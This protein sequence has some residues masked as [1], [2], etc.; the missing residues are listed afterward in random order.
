M[1]TELTLWRI[2]HAHNELTHE[3]PCPNIEGSRR[4]LMSYLDSLM[5]LKQFPEADVTKGKMVLDENR[6]F[7]R[8]KQKEP[9]ATMEKQKWKPPQDN[10]AKM[11]VDG[12]FSEDGRAGVGMVLRDSSGAV[13]LAAC[14]RVTHCQDAT[15][16][17]L[18]AIE[19][20]IQLGLQ[21]TSMRFCVE[22]DCADAIELIKHPSLNLS[23]HA[24]RINVIREL[25]EERDI[26]LAK[27]HRTAN[28][29][30]DALARL[31]RIQGRTNTWFSE[32]P[33]EIAAMIDDDCS[34]IQA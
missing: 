25:L 21:W 18:M 22:S 13:L 31:G 12:T 4:F 33:P 27:V 11:N 26:S 9:R 5:L 15:E 3:K 2:W 34:S 7:K 30:S 20:G 14:R 24:F 19:D 17:E 6:G 1:E 32:A 29:A 8:G 10:E 16:A 23:A 28:T